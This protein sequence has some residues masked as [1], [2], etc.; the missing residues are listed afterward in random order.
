VSRAARYL[1]FLPW[2]LLL[3]LTGSSV[4]VREDQKLQQVLEEF[5]DG[6]K[7]LGIA[8]RPLRYVSH[9][10][11]IQQET[12]LTRQQ[13]FFEQAATQ[14][15]AIREDR[16][17]GI[18]R[19]YYRQWR[20]ELG[21]NQERI[22]LEKRYRASSPVLTEEGLARQ[23]LGR[24]WYRYFLKEYLS[25]EISPEELKAFGLQEVQKVQQQIRQVQQ[26]TGYAQ[27]SAGFYQQLQDSSFFLEDEEEILQAYQEKY[28]TA[29][30]RMPW[31]FMPSAIPALHF[32]KVANADQDTPPGYYSGENR[33]FYFNF[34]GQR[35]NKR[36]MDFLLLHEGIPGHHYQAGISQ[37]SSGQNPLDGLVWYFGY[38]EGWA[39]YCEELGQELGL[40]QTPYDYY[41]KLEW[42]LVRSVRVVLDV[43]LNYEGWTREQALA[44][45]KQHIPHQDAIAL[46]EINRMLR[47][48]VQVHTY[49]VG[50]DAILKLRQ[51]AQQEQGPRFDIRRF[52][53]QFLRNGPLPLAVLTEQKVN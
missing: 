43:G 3:G 1:A 38:S 41:G 25:L 10:S 21:L 24:E 9:L 46:R 13:Q 53:D 47:W 26:E 20:Y 15:K 31:L 52:H 35:H 44:F 14:A 6:Y 30:A 5:A 49:K 2:F 22:A 42:D 39:A 37:V 28:K 12:G 36:S 48:P 32:A 19:L 27:D 40:Y 50:A 7:R 29:L 17:T 11:N 18:N 34:Y 33:T 23:Q 4:E 45:W 16:L 51:K 8:G